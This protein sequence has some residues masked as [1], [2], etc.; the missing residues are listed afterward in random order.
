M[1]KVHG[2]AT[3]KGCLSLLGGRRWLVGDNLVYGP[4]THLKEE[5]GK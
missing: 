4:E 3:E 5:K 1:C 2:E